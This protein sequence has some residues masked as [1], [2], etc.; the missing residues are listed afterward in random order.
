MV[1]SFR[2]FNHSNLYQLFYILFSEKYFN[3]TGDLGLLAFLK[4]ADS[5]VCHVNEVIAADS[6][7][8]LPVSLFHLI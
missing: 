6:K 8:L 3:L 1:A 2:Q 5:L 4:W 7:K